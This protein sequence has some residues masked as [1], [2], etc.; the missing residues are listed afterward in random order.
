MQVLGIEIECRL[1]LDVD[2]L[3][4]LLLSPERAWSLIA[5]CVAFGRSLAAMTAFLFSV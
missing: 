4:D 5:P 2:Y 1:E 3:I